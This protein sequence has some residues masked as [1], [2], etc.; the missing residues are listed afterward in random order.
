MTD[1]AYELPWE[2]YERLKKEQWADDVAEGQAATPMSVHGE[3]ALTFWHQLATGTFTGGAAGASLTTL[4]RLFKV[5]SDADLLLV[6]L[7][8]CGAVRTGVWFDPQFAVE[9]ADEM[10]K[11][12]GAAHPVTDVLRQIGQ[13]WLDEGIDGKTPMG[14]HLLFTALLYWCQGNEFTWANYEAMLP[15]LFRVTT[16]ELLGRLQLLGTPGRVAQVEETID[17]V[18]ELP[19]KV[20]APV[21]VRFEN[22]AWGLKTKD[23]GP[24]VWIEIVRDE[25][26]VAPTGRHLATLM[27]V[28]DQSVKDEGGEYW[29]VA[30]PSVS[31]RQTFTNVI[32]GPAEVPDGWTQPADDSPPAAGTAG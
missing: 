5:F 24:Y 6:K 32:I 1:E 25:L 21:F 27:R 13:S 16:A 8:G 23:F 31:R 17:R 2:K 3:R 20:A 4:A 15:R 22:P 18:A 28:H 10:E 11:Q 14:P 9:Q 19:V 30:D 29:V 7:F 12:S 26:K